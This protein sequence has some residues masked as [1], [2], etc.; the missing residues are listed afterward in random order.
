M[1]L[2]PIAD[3]ELKGSLVLI[4]DDNPSDLKV[5]YNSLYPYG[6]KILLSESGAEGIETAL[7]TI[8]DL[9]LLDILMPEMDGFEICN[10]LKQD[11]RTKKIPIILITALTETDDKV[12]G[13]KLGA[14]DYITKPFSIEEVAARITTHLKLKCLNEDLK[15]AIDIRT[16]E[17]QKTNQQ[18]EYEIETRVKSEAEIQR[19]QNFL[20]NIVNSMPSMI[21]G[22]DTK[23][24]VTHW[25]TA[26]QN[27]T[28]ISASQIH[29]S[30]L[31]KELL[32]FM[33]NNDCV[34][35]AIT[36]QDI[37]VHRRIRVNHKK[38]TR[39]FDLTVYPLISQS[40]E[41]AVIRIDDATDRVLFEEAMI[42]NEKMMTV[43]GL[44]AG[45]AHEINNPLAGILQS[46]EV[47]HKRF[48]NSV[49]KNTLTADE[50]D[51][52]LKNMNQY[53]EKRQIFQMLDAAT[54]S[55]LRIKKII[56]NMLSFSRKS[57]SVFTKEDVIQLV[58]NAIE[59]AKNEYNMKKRLDFL[60]VNIIKEYNQDTPQILC[61]ANKI[62]QVI[63]NLLKN[64]TQALA[65][66]ASQN[67]QI[68]VIVKPDGEYACIEIRDNGP[69]MDKETANHAFDPFFT[70]KNIGEGTGLGLS[71]S[72][73]I[74]TDNH[75]GIMSVRSSPGQGAAFTIKL[76]V[77]PSKLDSN[78]EY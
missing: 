77:D 65:D 26:A 18:L 27:A 75:N 32:K 50:C 68:T 52:R 73:F 43:G 19:L 35:K 55:G 34:Q 48:S 51:I 7:S 45:M 13:F 14:V 64:S 61:E 36:N 71:I 59:L 28:K 70:T 15:H 40:K 74:I 63:L 58:D 41:G 72:Y 44:A 39:F 25:N 67:P 5:L 53:M 20:N 21:V 57:P 60:N 17:L 16:K 47:V 33:G 49:E 78:I 10:K 38:M 6:Y 3:P 24:F 76:P 9:I 66:I 69:G 4:I 30:P 29:G 1:S 11:E 22:V 54:T 2:M 23:G 46:I 37:Q 8:P 56:Q 42:Q 12:E 31:P 62:Q